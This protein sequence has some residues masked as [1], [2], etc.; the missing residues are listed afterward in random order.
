MVPGVPGGWSMTVINP[1]GVEYNRSCDNPSPSYG[2]LP[3]IGDSLQTASCNTQQC[4]GTFYTLY[5]ISIVHDC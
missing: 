2:G 5:T 4:P 3:C 1:V